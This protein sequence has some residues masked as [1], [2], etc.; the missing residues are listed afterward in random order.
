M[1]LPS[2][3]SQ[4]VDPEAAVNPGNSGGPVLN[5]VTRW[6]G[7]DGWDSG[8]GHGKLILRLHWNKSQHG[9]EIFVV[10]I[11]FLYMSWEILIYRRVRSLKTWNLA[12]HPVLSKA[13]RLESESAVRMRFDVLGKFRWNDGTWIRGS[14]KAGCMTIIYSYIYIRL[15]WLYTTTICIYIYIYIK[16]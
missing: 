8:D 7:W 16:I 4:G 2:P 9:M 1:N 3:S 11:S 14:P 13:I 12:F 5:E 6:L 10:S 15:I